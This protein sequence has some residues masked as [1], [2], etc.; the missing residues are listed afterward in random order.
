[1]TTWAY[2]GK[3]LR[4]VILRIERSSIYDGDGFRTVV[5]MKGCPLRCKW[6]STPESW[7]FVKPEEA[8]RLVY[9][10]VMTVEE[11]MKEIRKDSLFYFH[12]GGGMTISGGELLIQPEFC[13]CLL[14]QSRKEGISTAIETALYAGWDRLEPILHSASTVFADLKFVDR[15]LHK[16][17]CGVYNDQ[18]LDNYLKMNETAADFELRV[19]IPLIPTINDSVQELNRMGEFC[20]KLKKLA[21]VQLLPYHRLG[22]D[23]YRRLNMKYEL[24]ELRSPSPEHMDWCRELIGQYVKVVK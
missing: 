2:E 17:Y 8:D 9:G 22:K 14:Q 11:V 15:A 20:T 10:R 4:G 12:S 19:R 13:R 1:M 7:C 24:E 16:E 23:T 21:Y 5:F 6:C 18:I 3:N